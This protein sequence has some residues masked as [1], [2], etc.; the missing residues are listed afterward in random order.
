MGEVCYQGRGRRQEMLYKGGMEEVSWRM[1]SLV[2]AYIK[3][4]FFLASI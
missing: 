2:D 4:L 1:K 3:H